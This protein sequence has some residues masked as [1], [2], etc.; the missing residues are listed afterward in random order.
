MEKGLE[1]YEMAQNANY[2]FDEGWEN[3]FNNY[4]ELNWIPRFIVIDQQ[5]KIA[6]YYAISPT[7]PDLQKTIEQLKSEKCINKGC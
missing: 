2:W 3:V 6:K 1:K 4:V 5:G 7:D